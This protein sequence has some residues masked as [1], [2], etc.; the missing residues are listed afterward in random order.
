MEPYDNEIELKV[1][2]VWI[3][4]RNDK[5][6]DGPGMSVEAF[7]NGRMLEREIYNQ[8]GNGIAGVCYV[9]DEKRGQP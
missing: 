1:R 5:S 6:L 9:E 3:S 8:H 4:Y 7:L 2:L